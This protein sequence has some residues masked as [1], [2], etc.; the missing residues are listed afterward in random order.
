[1]NNEIITKL[2][3]FAYA[4]AVT[5]V[6]TLGVCPAFGIMA[7]SVGAVFKSKGVRLDDKNKKKIKISLILGVL[8]L[9][10][11]AADIAVLLHFAK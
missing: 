1:M 6:C 7:I 5:G 2:T 10:L 4:M 8:S 3:K 11:F 9:L